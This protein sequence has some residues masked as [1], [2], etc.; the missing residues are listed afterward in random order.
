MYLV[1]LEI[2][3]FGSVNEEDNGKIYLPIDN[4]NIVPNEPSNRPENVFRKPRQSPTLD[5]HDG[6]RRKRFKVLI[7]LHDSLP[8]DHTS[9]LCRIRFRPRVPGG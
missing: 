5:R 6:F 1:R 7:V 9:V 4:R 8:I 2:N 3:S